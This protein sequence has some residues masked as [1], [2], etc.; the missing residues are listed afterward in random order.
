MLIEK[1]GRYIRDEGFASAARR[2]ATYLFHLCASNIYRSHVELLFECDLTESPP[3]LP[4]N[5]LLVREFVQDDTAAV[6][7]FIRQH[8]V[9]ADYG[10]KRFAFNTGHG[11]RA[12]L[13]T[14]PE[15]EIVGYG[16]LSDRT[17]PHPAQQ[18]HG[19]RLG[20][21]ELYV[22][23]LFVA[24]PFRRSTMALEFLIRARLLGREQ[25]FNRILSNILESN[26]KSI[27]LHHHAGFREIDRHRVYTLFNLI[28]ICGRRAAIRNS[29]WF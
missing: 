13:A 15:G 7:Q 16:W 8:N 10:L 20:P 28:M 17:K 1:L 2:V 26:R 19:I 23:D 22:F 9:H 6:Q 24:P 21:G 11:Y 18:L 27:R 25:H 4:A 3:E 5:R 12:V 29:L 14:T